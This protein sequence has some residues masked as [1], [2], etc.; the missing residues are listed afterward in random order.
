MLIVRMVELPSFVS[1]KVFH[2]IGKPMFNFNMHRVA[3]NVLSFP[4]CP[5]TNVECLKDILESGH[6]NV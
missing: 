3:F 2:S 5:T 1:K 6:W 4:P